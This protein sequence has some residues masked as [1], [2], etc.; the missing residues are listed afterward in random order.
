MSAYDILIRPFVRNMDLDRA[1][2]I[3]LKYFQLMGR[4]PFG[5]TVNRWIHGNRSSGLEKEVFGLTFYNPIGLGAGLDLYGEQYNGLSNI[6]FS[7][8]EIGPMGADGIRRAIRHLQED[9]KSGLVAACIDR[10]Y[11][12]AMTLA[13]DFCD[14]FVI[15]LSADPSTEYLDALLEARISEQVYKP[16]V[17]KIPEYLTEEELGQITDY[18][19]L[20]SVDGIESRSITQLRHISAY[21]GGRLP[22]IAN[23]HIDTPQQAQE[24]LE[25]GADLVEIRTG[26]VKEGPGIVKRML[27]HLQEA[28]KRQNDIDA[29]LK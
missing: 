24:A 27:R 29:V 25:A 19:L 17:A 21:S 15:D 12:T 20:N 2:R 18:C 28:E 6:G 14:F 16:I 11:L 10:E 5:R 1:S 26:L 8:T 4:V 13:Y 9:P 22:I 7:F 3:S 23:S